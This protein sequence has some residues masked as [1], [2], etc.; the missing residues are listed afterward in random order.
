MSHVSKI[1]LVVNDLSA[2]EAAANELG[3]EMVKGQTSFR[4]YGRF[5]ND[6]HAD[7]AAYKSGVN[8]SDYGKC[9]HA[10]RIPDNNRAYEIGVTDNGN[11]TYTLVWDLYQGGYGLAARIGP[12]GEKLNQTYV[13]HRVS[14]ELKKQGFKLASEEVLD[15]GNLK[16]TLEGQISL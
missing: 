13:K 5:M 7:D 10:L 14:A 6:Y 2:L 11:G 3:L 1:E 16:L 8:P 15:N 4:W 12:K 9:A